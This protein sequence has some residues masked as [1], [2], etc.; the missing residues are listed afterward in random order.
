VH[1]SVWDCSLSICRDATKGGQGGRI[2]RAPS[3][4]GG[5][6]SLRGVPKKSQQCHKYFLQC[7]TLASERPQFRTWGRQTCFLLRAPSNLITLLSICLNLFRF[8]TSAC[9]AYDKTVINQCRVDKSSFEDQSEEI[10]VWILKWMTLLG[11]FCK[12]SFMPAVTSYYQV[13]ALNADAHIPICSAAM[14]LRCSRCRNHAAVNC[15]LHWIVLSLSTLQM[16]VSSCITLLWLHHNHKMSTSYHK[17]RIS[18]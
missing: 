6:K 3:N 14:L 17:K 16:G 4:D 9:F 18:Q 7:S 11:I 10:S 5:A 13:H 2:H 8:T 15:I 1:G 12:I